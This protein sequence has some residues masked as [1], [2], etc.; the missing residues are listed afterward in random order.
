MKSENIEPTITITVK[1]YSYLKEMAEWGEALNQSGV[2]NWEGC[3]Y[4]HELIE[5][6]NQEIKLREGTNE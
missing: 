3:S 1:E 2:D 6:W 4:A 5:Q